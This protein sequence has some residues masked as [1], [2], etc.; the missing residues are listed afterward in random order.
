M[1]IFN[2]KKPTMNTQHNQAVAVQ[3][4]K[5]KAVVEKAKK[6]SA[7]LNNMIEENGFTVTIALAMGAKQKGVTHN[8][9]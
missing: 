3:Q 4:S 7:R 1:G 6:A 8:G 5:N 9:H 2:L